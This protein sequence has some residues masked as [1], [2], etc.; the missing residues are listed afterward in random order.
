[1]AKSTTSKAFPTLEMVNARAA[2]L[3]MSYG[4]HCSSKQYEA[5]ITSGWYF[6]NY[7]RKGKRKN[8]GQTDPS[9]DD[10]GAE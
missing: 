5:D 1:M 6:D 7:T 4:A 10:K 2:E 8:A 3:E 9:T